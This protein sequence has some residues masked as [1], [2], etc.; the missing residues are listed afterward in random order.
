MQIIQNQETLAQQIEQQEALLVL[1]GGRDCNVCHAIKPK[2]KETVGEQF[3]K[4]AMVYIDCHE[5]TD[6]CAQY[7]V[8]SLPTVQVYFTGQRFIELVRTFSVPQLIQQ[9]E[10]P[11]RMLFSEV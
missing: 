6:I 9:I 7:G 8:L 3:P 11:Y 2:I 5:T 10:R 1:F 4:M